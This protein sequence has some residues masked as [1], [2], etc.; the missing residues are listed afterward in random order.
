M[1]ARAP[2]QSTKTIEPKTSVIAIA[3]SE[4]RET[5]RRTALAKAASTDPA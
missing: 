1:T 4:A 5:L 2:S 3:V